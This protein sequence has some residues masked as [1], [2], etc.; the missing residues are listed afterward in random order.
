MDQ[1]LVLDF[2]SPNKVIFLRGE[3]TV[4]IH[5][6]QLISF[7]SQGAT[8]GKSL[9]TYTVYLEDYL[10]KR[11]WFKL[12]WVDEGRSV[13]V[14]EALRSAVN[15]SQEIRNEFEKALNHSINLDTDIALHGLKR[16]LTTEQYNNV[17]ISLALQNGANFSVPGA[18]K[19][20]TTL[21]VWNHLNQ[22][23]IIDNLLVICPKSAFEAWS[24]S[25]LEEIFEKPPYSQEL[26]SK[27]IH[28]STKILISNYEKLENDI[29]LEKLILWIQSRSVMMV[30]DEAHRIKGGI[31]SVRWR[32]CKKVAGFARRVDLLTG[33]PM[34]QGYDD[35]RNLFNLSWGCL[36]QKYLTDEKLAQITPNSVF[37][38]TTKEELKLPPVE[39]K[40]IP[41]EPSDLQ[42]EIYS[43]L[44]HSYRGFLKVDF[45]D[46]SKLGQMGKAV[47]SLI[48]AASNPGLILGKQSE[49]AFLNLQWPPA[50]V[51]SDS[52]LMEIIGNYVSHEMPPKYKWL[53]QFINKSHREGKKT[54]VWSNFVGNLFS[55]ER[56]LAQY[57]PAL[58]C[59]SVSQE[60]RKELLA[61]FREDPKC[62][63][64][65]TN[66]Q[67]LGEGISLHRVC[68]QAV[69][70][71]RTYNAGHYLQSLDR[72]H[73][74][75]LPK[76]VITNIYVLTTNKTIDYRI[77][78]RLSEKVNRMAGMLSDEGLV[79]SSG[80]IYD[81]TESLIDLNVID[82]EDAD[83]LFRHLK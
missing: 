11:K 23:E 44:K 55:L 51:S 42:M 39:I 15:H 72:I 69:Y 38:R 24:G 18:G 33:T 47:M 68:N 46:K 4:S 28:S 19:T 27:R 78:V 16:T 35:L 8:L 10:L 53:A 26:D 80:V 75:G 70:I 34:P 6:D 61:R 5:W 1:E 50:E 25:E 74:L 82:E 2:E 71:D 45:K 7:W 52:D 56:L 9:E 21:A 54:L 14:T 62:S 73:R 37:V 40:E 81:E 22:K 49:D 58:I 79:A 59:G 67:T 17:K 66:P 31:Q 63:V 13:Q 30:L 29:F 20:T 36:P 3:G 48:V 12:K 77:N 41:I 76:D 60:D 64:L 83:D 43:S 32:A 57:N 65:L